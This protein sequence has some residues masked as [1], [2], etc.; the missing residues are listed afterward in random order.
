MVKIY[1]KSLHYKI[2]YIIALL[3]RLI[4]KKIKENLAKVTLNCF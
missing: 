1:A 4:S 2:A 3:I